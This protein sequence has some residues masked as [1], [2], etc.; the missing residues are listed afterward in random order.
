M[1]KPSTASQCS[2]VVIVHGD[3]RLRKL[4]DIFKVSTPAEEKMLWMSSCKIGWRKAKF[5]AGGTSLRSSHL[6]KLF[7]FSLAE[8]SLP[9]LLRYT[10]IIVSLNSYQYL[11]VST[12]CSSLFVWFVCKAKV[13]SARKEKSLRYYSQATEHQPSISP[14]ISSILSIGPGTSWNHFMMF[15][16]CF[17]HHFTKSWMVH[18]KCI[19]SIWTI[20][21]TKE[22]YGRW[23]LGRS[24][25]LV[26][27]LRQEAN[28]EVGAKWLGNHEQLWLYHAL[29]WA[30]YP[31]YIYIYICIYNIYI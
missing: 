8:Q 4:T 15:Y 14:S 13:L 31:M 18:G 1:L 2:N 22:G 9:N 25:G 27:H 21:F 19:S 10:M 11:S 28:G 7:R 29:S 12:C 23:W 6:P 5:L 20:H 24:R 3:A 30:K 26:E 17:M 16:A